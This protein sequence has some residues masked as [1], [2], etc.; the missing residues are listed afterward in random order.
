VGQKEGPMSGI[1]STSTVIGS[2]W[3]A[4]HPVN[5]VG[6]NQEDLTLTDGK[7]SQWNF[8][9]RRWGSELPLELQMMG[10]IKHMQ[11]LPACEEFF[12]TQSEQNASSTHKNAEALK[13]TEFYRVRS[14]LSALDSG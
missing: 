6:Y 3:L 12:P 10:I 11:K 13:K 8:C 7:S 4:T 9:T 5:A 2:L 14:K 1:L